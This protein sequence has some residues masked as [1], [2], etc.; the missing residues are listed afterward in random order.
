M[1]RWIA[2]LIFALASSAYPLEWSRNNIIKISA[3]NVMS[4]RFVTEAHGVIATNSKILPQ[5]G[6]PAQTALEAASEWRSMPQG[7]DPAILA[8]TVPL[9]PW[10][11]TDPI[12][13]GSNY[14][15]ASAFVNMASSAPDSYVVMRLRNRFTDEV[16]F[17]RRFDGASSCPLTDVFD[18]EIV[19][20]L[21]FYGNSLEVYSFGLKRLLEELIK[22][23]DVALSPALMFYGEDDLRID[24]KL[25]APSWLDVIVFDKNGTLI[26][27]VVNKTFLNEGEYTYRWDPL[28]SSTRG[29]LASGLY[30]VYFSARSMDGQT[31]EVSRSFEFVN[32]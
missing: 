2:V 23:E 18:K 10:L 15:L 27:Y 11:R 4:S 26:D 16:L 28:R 25:R 1:K 22:P 31:A 17:E 21:E 29:Q 19:M 30:Y 5:P 7:D 14:I 9:N 20:T 13:V 8:S 3:D 32:K 12:S 24:F 6:Y